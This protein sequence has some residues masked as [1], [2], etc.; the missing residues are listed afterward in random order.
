M[1]ASATDSPVAAEAVADQLAQAG[2]TIVDIAAGN[3][4]FSTLVTAVQAADLV[5]VLSGEGPFTVFAPTND[6]FAAL[7]TEVLEA[8]LLPENQDLLTDVLAYHVVP[9]IV[10]SDSLV[11]PG[12]IETLNGPVRVR[13]SADEVIVNDANVVLADV[14]ASNGII[15][16]IDTVLIP[17]GLVDALTA[18][19]AE[20]EMAEVSETPVVEEAVVTPAPTPTTAPATT[21]PTVSEPVQGLW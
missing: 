19:M 16:A 3:S 1:P 2:D 17:A 10:T 5:D 9:D 21:A 8:L 15:H 20:A 11:S 6:A 13:S 14:E 4:A 18:R 7:P 12:E